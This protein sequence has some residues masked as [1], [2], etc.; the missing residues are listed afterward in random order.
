[1]FITDEDVPQTCKNTTTTLH[2][3]HLTAFFPGQ[4]G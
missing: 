4:C 3:I 1:M 2:Y